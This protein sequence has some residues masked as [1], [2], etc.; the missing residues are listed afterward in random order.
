MTLREPTPV[1]RVGAEQIGRSFT[2]T[3]VCSKCGDE[4][5]IDDF[6]IRGRRGA[7]KLRNVCKKCQKIYEEKI[8]PRRRQRYLDNKDEILQKCKNYRHKN[9]EEISRRRALRREEFNITVHLYYNGCCFICGV[10]DSC[11]EMY[12]CHHIDP[13]IKDWNISKA[14]ASPW[15]TVVIPEL[16][17]CIYLCSNCHRKLHGHR[18]DEQIK[19]GELVLVPGRKT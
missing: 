14:Y 19:T 3:K 4:K 8:K 12:D 15:D 18:F 10:T 1:Q 5:S 16:E 2:E 17:K 7:S 13:S 11:H 9:R 6:N